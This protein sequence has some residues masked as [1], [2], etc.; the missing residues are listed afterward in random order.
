MDQDAEAQLAQLV[1]GAQGGAPDAQGGMMPPMAPPEPPP[2]RNPK[3]MRLELRLTNELLARRRRE[4]LMPPESLMD[5]PNRVEFP[6]LRAPREELAPL[7]P[8]PMNFL[9]Q[10]GSEAMGGM[11]MPPDPMM[12]G[13][14]P[15][16]PML[17]G[18]PAPVPGVGSEPP[19]VVDDPSLPPEELEALGG[20]L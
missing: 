7:P 13:A 18:A 1:A 10:M 19:E 16:D 5:T 8:A 9:D 2:T 14:A 12:D 6:I 3:V 20:L 17:E 15:P 4:D 11:A